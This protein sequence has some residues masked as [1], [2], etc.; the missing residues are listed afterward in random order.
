MHKYGSMILLYLMPKISLMNTAHRESSVPVSVTN[1]S[2]WWKMA[3]Q[4]LSTLFAGWSES[5]NPSLEQIE[6]VNII[7]SNTTWLRANIPP[8][9]VN[10]K[11]CISTDFYVISVCCH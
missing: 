5:T 9:Q 6:A 4:K 11:H 10:I 1:I 7:I 3:I 2:K 8:S